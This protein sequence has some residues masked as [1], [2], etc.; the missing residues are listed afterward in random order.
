MARP[1]ERID[2]RLHHR[3]EQPTDLT[4]SKNAYYPSILVIFARIVD[5]ARLPGPVK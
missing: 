1:V 2:R 5:H 4:G 3:P